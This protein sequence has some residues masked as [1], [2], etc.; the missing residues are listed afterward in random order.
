MRVL[1]AEDDAASRS[2]VVRWLERWGHRVSQ[3][4]DGEAAWTEICKPTPPR[5]V[6][7]DWRMPGCDG[8]ELIGRLS[9]LQDEHSRPHVIMLTHHGEQ[10]NLVTALEA[11]ADDYM[12]KP[13]QPAELKARLSVARRLLLN[14][15]QLHRKSLALE[16]YGRQMH[17]LAESRAQQL[18]HAERLATLGTLAAGIAHEIRNP[19]AVISG[20]VQTLERIWPTLDRN[21]DAGSCTEEDRPALALARQSM[22][23]VCRDMRQSVDRV[24]DIVR[25]LTDFSRRD[26]GA[27]SVCDLNACVQTA[28]DL[29]RQ[30][31]LK[32]IHVEC[33][34]AA[35]LPSVLIAPRE[36]E[37]VLVNLLV[38]AALAVGKQDAP[39]VRISTRQHHDLQVM[40]E[41]NGPG[42]APDVLQRLWDPFFTT[43]PAGKGTGLGLT[44]SR[45]I[46][47]RY[48]GRLDAH[49]RQDGGACFTLALPAHVLGD[50]AA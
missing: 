6:I 46:A 35:G 12:I 29:T 39:V 33:H 18:Y 22:P 7:L 9:E 37:Q 1:V 48:R 16:R 47:Q 49:N 34:L 21:L 45:T 20:N 8:L 11:G 27:T 32:H 44:I 36:I 4:A 38:N 50:R 17:R 31:A 15:M 30:T 3:A 40:V 28:L 23:A 19:A 42:L 5:V 2:V 14:E 43:R 26:G 25:Q 24:A 10:E 13:M 41:D